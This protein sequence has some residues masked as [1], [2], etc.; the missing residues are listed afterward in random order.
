M[1]VSTLNAIRTQKHMSISAP[2]I[3]SC[4]RLRQATSVK[5]TEGFRIRDRVTCRTRCKGKANAASYG[6]R[7]TAENARNSGVFHTLAHPCHGARTAVPGDESET[8]SQSCSWGARPASVASSFVTG[9][10]KTGHICR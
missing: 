2:M 5:I 3:R 1:T 10:A 8:G 6:F 7:E 4:L 9:E